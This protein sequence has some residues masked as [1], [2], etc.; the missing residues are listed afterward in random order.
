V[1]NCASDYFLQ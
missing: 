1:T